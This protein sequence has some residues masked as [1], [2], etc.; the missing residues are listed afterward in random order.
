MRKKNNIAEAL[1]LKSRSRNGYVAATFSIAIVLF[2]LGFFFSF[3]VLGKRFFREH[4]ETIFLKVSLQDNI[5]TPL[6]KELETDIKAAPYCK[7][8]QFV[9]KEAALKLFIS[10][11]GDTDI[12]KLLEGVNPL[13]ASWEI[14]LTPDY[15]HIDSVMSIQ[16]QLRKNHIVA[17][18]DYPVELVSGFQKNMQNAVFVSLF[19][20]VIATLL[21]VYLVMN[22]IKLRIYAERLII[23]T[24]QLIGATD[25]FIRKPYIR[26]GI[27]QGFL[28]G[29]IACIILI[30]VLMGLY[31]RLAPVSGFPRL[32]INIDFFAILMGILLFGGLLGYGGSRFAVN[33]FL[34]VSI[35]ELI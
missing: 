15:I 33:R 26:A 28:A 18:V 16:Q 11:T 12:L 14:V 10:Q 7:S 21:T 5:A 4:Q 31:S 20:A 9:S 3:F 1:Y 6:I 13:Y 2:L 35:E 17:A 24:M 8:I 27:Q 30:L 34:N 32:I 25:S 22:T 29:G 23:R 19:I